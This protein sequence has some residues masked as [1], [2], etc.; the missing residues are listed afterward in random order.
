LIQVGWVAW[1]AIPSDL[2]V[3]AFCVLVLM[4][5]A[6][7][8]WAE[9]AAR[10]SWHPGHIA[11]R[12]G[13]FTIIVLGEI[14]LVTS[15]GVRSALDARSTY[16]E[17]AYVVIGGLLTVFSMWWIYFDLPTEEIVADTRQA[18]SKA[19]T[20]AFSWGYGHYLVYAGAAATSAG[21]GLAIDRVTGHSK[22]SGTPTGMALS[23][24]VALFI[25]VVWSLHFRY[26]PSTWVRNIA[27]PVAVVLI[28][29]SGAT[30]EPALVTGLLMVGLVALSIV[31]AVDS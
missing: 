5:L 8:I 12:Y 15:L 18:F 1:L 6:V 14:L 21:L 3:P 22:L 10:T 31:A 20:G 30:P 2:A 11:E 4:E 23:I 7:P 9:S 25:L 19:L 13:L 24:P 26:K 29:A 17:L 27:V 28:V 16:S